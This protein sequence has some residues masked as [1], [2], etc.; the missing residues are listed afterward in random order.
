MPRITFKKG[1]AN[2]R[3]TGDTQLRATL[4]KLEDEIPKG[5]ALALGDAGEKIKERAQ[6]LLEDAS[7]ARTGK[8]YWTGTLQNTIR[9]TLV[10]GQV[11]ATAGK[12]IGIV[13]GPALGTV[14]YAGYVEVGHATRGGNWWEGYHYM[15]NAFVQ[16]YDKVMRDIE[17]AVEARVNEVASG[18][19]KALPGRNVFKEMF[20]GNK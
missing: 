9:P 8:K 12:T 5:M 2:L 10:D 1:S 14:S 17:K 13:V 7:A 18:K 15:E 3:M 6:Q 16:L 4:R 19:V 11:I 20:P